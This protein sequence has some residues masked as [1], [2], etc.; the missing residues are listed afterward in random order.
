[1]LNDFL[2]HYSKSDRRAMI[3]LVVLA[4]LLIVILLIVD[5]VQTGKLAKVQSQVNSKNE[6]VAEKGKDDGGG[7]DIKHIPLH[8]FDPNTVDSATLVGFGIAPWKARILINYR[9]KGKRFST[10]ESIL[11]TYNWEESDYELLKPFIKIGEEYRKGVGRDA[12]NAYRNGAS[13][14]YDGARS[15]GDSGTS[16]GRQRGVETD[17]VK[18]NNYRSA[19][20]KTLTK[21][22]INTA[23]STTLCSIPGVGSYISMA[24]IRYRQKLGGFASVEQA[25]D[26]K[27][28]SP[29]LLEWFKVGEQPNISKININKDSFQKL[30]SHPYVSYEQTRDLLSYRRLY[31]KINDEAQLLS[32]NIFSKEEVQK[33]RPYLE[34]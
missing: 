27:Q 1:M 32:I 19:K 12:H 8:D 15:Y 17:S 10:P 34:Y 9:N 26:I 22:D 23:D 20:F 28:V 4:V 2:K 13:R 5:I 16:A 18:K 7:N 3:A 31:G 11:D 25:L 14:E 24:I 30:N 21:V 33:L 29:E 6:K